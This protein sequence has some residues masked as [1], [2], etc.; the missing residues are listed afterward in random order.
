ML[1][2]TGQLEEVTQAGRVMCFANTTDGH[3]PVSVH[4]TDEMLLNCNDAF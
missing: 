2:Q 3:G 1:A 4:S